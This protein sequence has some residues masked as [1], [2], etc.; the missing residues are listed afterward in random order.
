MSLG[1][2][3][4]FT[5]RPLEA[6]GEENSYSNSDRNLNYYVFREG[7]KNKQVYPYEIWVF[8]SEQINVL[9]F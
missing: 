1:G 3:R 5:D 6:R 2:I 9:I 7:K 4:L 8:T